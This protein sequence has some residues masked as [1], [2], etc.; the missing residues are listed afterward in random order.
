MFVIKKPEEPLKGE[1]KVIKSYT[2]NVKNGLIVSNEYSKLYFYALRV[3][4]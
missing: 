2:F 1:E 3:K 4:K